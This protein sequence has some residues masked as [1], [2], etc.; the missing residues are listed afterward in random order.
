MS[1]SL[2][3][4]EGRAVDDR[5][6]DDALAPDVRFALLGRL[7]VVVGGRD[8]APTA[9]R[10]LQLL[11]LLLLRARQVVPTDTIVT[12]LW[13]DR[14]PKRA[15]AAVQTHVYQL[16]RCIQQLGLVGEAD[17]VLVTRAPGYVLEVDP[18]RTDLHTFTTGCG[19]GRPR[20][21]TR[22]RA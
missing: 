21:R 3:P 16:R 5:P 18:A 17:D 2:I 19:P 11:A 9:P 13:G 12:E 20:G 8:V 22:E 15:R 7:E 6:V 4:A 1:L 10:A 14:P